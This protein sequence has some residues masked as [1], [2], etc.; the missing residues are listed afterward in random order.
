MDNIFTERL[1]RTVKYEDIYIKSYSTVDEAREGLNLYFPFYNK[2]RPHQSLNYR[3]PEEI[4][5][6]GSPTKTDRP[7]T[8]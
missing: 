2:K 4:Y 8:I 6:G 1:W 7:I 3:T 5:R